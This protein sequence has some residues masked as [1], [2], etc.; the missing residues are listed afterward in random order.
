MEFSSGVLQLLWIGG[1]AAVPIALVVGTLCRLRS[2]R[3]ATRHLLWLAALASFVS[4]AIGTMIWRPSWFRTDRIIAVADRV[5]PPATAGAAS[6]AGKGSE[7]TTPRTDRGAVPAPRP[8]IEANRESGAARAAPGI[9]ARRPVMPPASN[10]LYI[11]PARTAG[12]PQGGMSRGASLEPAIA[13]APHSGNASP[14]S[15]DFTRCA[16]AERDAPCDAGFMETAP[17]DHPASGLVDRT[18]VHAPVSALSRTDVVGVTSGILSALPPMPR[19]APDSRPTS[20]GYAGTVNAEPAAAARPL[21]APPISRPMSA[22]KSLRPWIAR[23]LDVRDSIAALPPVSAEIWLGVAAILV[24]VGLSRTM[25]TARWV[26]RARPAEPGVQAEVHAIASRMGLPRAPEA[27]VVDAAVS[28]MIWCG[29]RPRLIL[30]KAL[31]KALDV[32]SRRAVIAHELAHLHRRDHIFCWLVYAIGVLYWWH[33]VAWWARRRL[34]DEAEA[35]CDAWVTSLLPAS[36]R[37]YAAALVTTKSFLSAREPNAGACLGIMSGSA[38]RLARRITMVM[39]QKSAPRLSLIGACA[40]TIVIAA[41]MFVTPG[42]ACPPEESGKQAAKTAAG[43]VVVGRAKKAGSAADAPSVPFLGEAPALEA[44]KAGR[45]GEPGTPRVLVMPGTPQPPTPAITIRRD[46]GSASRAK[47]QATQP[48]DL[49][50]LKVGRT[51]REYKLSGGKLEAFYE[52]MSRNDIPVLVEM[53]GDRIAIWAKEDQ[54][55]VFESFIRMIDPESKQR[56]KPRSSADPLSREM[57]TA[58][59]L[60]PGADGRYKIKKLDK[61]EVKRYTEALRNLEAS[62]NAMENDADKARE[63]AEA[64]R[65]RAEQLRE[66]S[67]ELRER[68]KDLGEDQSRQALEQAYSQLRS[69]SD[70]LHN[71]SRSM[72]DR[73]EQIQRRIEELEKRAEE[74]EEQLSAL[75]DEDVNDGE[76][77]MGATAPSAEPEETPEAV[78]PPAAPEAPEP[79]EATEAPEATEVPPAPPAEPPPA[80]ASAPPAPPAALP[81]VPSSPAPGAPPAAR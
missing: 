63:D 12:A 74:L 60:V 45:P 20:S 70:V 65:E 28:P 27:V 53:R 57:A 73:V 33:P 32:H 4:P 30:P 37:A 22:A 24:L 47:V 51:A 58:M 8:S 41:G 68:A 43:V 81:P 13:S 5:L 50:Q 61:D 25:R 67:D 55:P 14:A 39:T 31:W 80:P 40:A 3:P 79:P 56:S 46:G 11:E 49:E 2:L 21:E 1:L 19:E 66:L 75:D 6:P 42:L 59:A 10:L 52:L 71:Q 54:H 69:R 15:S 29:L 78:E 72:N 7:A 16:P 48:L 26:S 23:V 76:Q 34:H 77:A 17:E 9:D 62:R 35:S 64:S 18:P 36:R 44:M 38:K